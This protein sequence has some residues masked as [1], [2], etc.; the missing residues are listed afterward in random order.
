MW[1]N[2]LQ[3][4]SQ[5]C[6][7]RIS[8]NTLKVD[9]MWQNVKRFCTLFRPECVKSICMFLCCFICKSVSAKRSRVV[10]LE[11]LRLI[12]SH[13]HRLSDVLAFRYPHINL[14]GWVS[15]EPIPRLALHLPCTAVRLDQSHMTMLS[16]SHWV[17]QE[18]IH[19]CKCGSGADRRKKDC[20]FDHF[21]CLRNM[22]SLTSCFINTILLGSDWS[23][24]QVQS[25]NT[26]PLKHGANMIGSVELY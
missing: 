12:S 11:K 23:L 3:S 1:Y 14:L 6:F 16:S 21:W 17:T 22:F 15:P 26:F 9:V 19:T 8:K 2:L 7:T 4:T 24:A 13:I 10:V 5:L 20:S 25:V 18:G